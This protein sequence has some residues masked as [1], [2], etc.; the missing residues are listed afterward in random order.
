MKNL[1]ILQYIDNT[2]VNFIDITK[3]D[4]NYSDSLNSKKLRKLP[5]KVQ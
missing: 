2:F 5:N 4:A 1:V 3:I